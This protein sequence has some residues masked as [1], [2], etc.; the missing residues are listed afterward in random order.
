[1]LVSEMRR[2]EATYFLINWETRGSE[3]GLTEEWPR[4]L[5][6]WPGSA[7]EGQHWSSLL[8]FYQQPLPSTVLP[9]PQGFLLHLSQGASSFWLLWP[10]FLAWVGALLSAPQSTTAH[11]RHQQAAPGLDTRISTWRQHLHAGSN[12]GPRELSNATSCITTL[13][14]CPLCV[15]YGDLRQ[16]HLGFDLLLL[17]CAQKGLVP[18]TH[19]LNP[20]SFWAHRPVLFLVSDCLFT[21]VSL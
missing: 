2:Q 8:A 14:P 18:S 20:G 19:P 10:C 9:A 5:W 7:A 4:G 17:S 16:E 1:M 12:W 15:A 11:A 13:S 3:Q 21:T 6:G